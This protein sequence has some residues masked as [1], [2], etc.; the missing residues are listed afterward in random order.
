[1]IFIDGSLYNYVNKTGENTYKLFSYCY[2]YSVTP[3]KVWTNIYSLPGS[4]V[5]S[6]LM[7]P[8]NPEITLN[9]FPNPATNALK[10][11]YSLPE[12]VTQA[13]LHL[14]DISGKQVEQFMVDNHTDHLMLDVSRYQS[15]VYHYFI[16][17]G[18]SRTE[19]KKLIVK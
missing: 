7:N 1:M 10:V 3:E 19:S 14:I 17:Y 18:H 2:D 9:A 6:A 5:V 13:T 8:K 16:E 12:N 4:P 15:G 11:A